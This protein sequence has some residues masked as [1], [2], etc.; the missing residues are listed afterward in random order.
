MA[1]IITIIILRDTF[2]KKIEIPMSNVC[3]DVYVE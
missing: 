2:N 1:T 3:G